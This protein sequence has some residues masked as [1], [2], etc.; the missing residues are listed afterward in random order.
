MQTAG[1]SSYDEASADRHQP[2]LDD[3]LHPLQPVER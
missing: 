3:G 1:P 2:N